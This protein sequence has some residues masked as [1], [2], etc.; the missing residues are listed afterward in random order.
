MKVKMILGSGSHSYS[1]L[2]L[3][4]PNGYDKIIYGYRSVTSLDVS[5]EWQEITYTAKVGSGS[6]SYHDYETITGNGIAL[7]YISGCYGDFV[8][9]K[10]VSVTKG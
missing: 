6:Y 5:E 1:R 7:A 4:G 8:L 10:D 3:L 9:I 2:H